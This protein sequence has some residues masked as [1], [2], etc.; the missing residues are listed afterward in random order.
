MCVVQYNMA[1]S[2]RSF[3]L[4]LKKGLET[5]LRVQPPWLLREG[6][7]G[8]FNFGACPLCSASQDLFQDCMALDTIHGPSLQV[9]WD[10]EGVQLVDRVLLLPLGALP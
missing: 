7:C 1:K 10:V 8:R 4:A 6:V 3:L 5:L 2:S 9:Y